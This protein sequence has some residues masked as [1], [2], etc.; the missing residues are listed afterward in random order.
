[1]K[2]QK[3]RYVEP[4][5]YRVTCRFGRWVTKSE[6]YFSANDPEEALNDF[7][8]A[9]AAGKPHANSVKVHKID[10]YDRFANK[11]FDVIKQIENYPVVLDEHHVSM[12]IEKSTK[13][14]KLKKT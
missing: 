13:K 11:W 12:K 2:K 4:N 10:Q 9:F 8:L 14:I 1:M 3:H 7:Y 6:R 5:V